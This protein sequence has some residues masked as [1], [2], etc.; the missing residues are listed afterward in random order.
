MT[1]LVSGAMFDWQS[2][3]RRIGCGMRCR[4]TVWLVVCGDELD[5]ARSCSSQQSWRRIQ[6]GSWSFPVIPYINWDDCRSTSNVVYHDSFQYAFQ[7]LIQSKLILELP[8]MDLLTKCIDLMKKMVMRSERV[9]HRH[10]LF[11]Q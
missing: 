2:A 11:K 3:L 9:N 10:K 6:R 4:L 5:C 8:P 7:V 1:V